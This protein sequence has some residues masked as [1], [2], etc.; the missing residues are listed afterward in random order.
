MEVK[1]IEE[2]VAIAVLKQQQPKKRKKKTKNTSIDSTRTRGVFTANL[3]LSPERETWIQLKRCS[4]VL[5][6]KYPKPLHFIRI[7]ANYFQVI[8]K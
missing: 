1:S 2:K 5:A 8:F 6:K 4:I 7:G 3:L